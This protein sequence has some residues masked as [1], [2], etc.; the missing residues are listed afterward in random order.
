MTH[1]GDEAPAPTG[2]TY[3]A[4]AEVETLGLLEWR[5]VR[6]QRALLTGPLGGGL[7][8]RRW[9]LNVQV[10]HDYRRLDPDRHLVDLAARLELPESG[11]GMLTAHHVDR[12][13]T[14]LDGGV[15]VTATVGL[16]RPILVVAGPAASPVPEA[17]TINIVAELP[18]RL[19]DAALANALVTVT[20]AKVQALHDAGVHAT[21]TASDAVSVL[22]PPDGE[23]HPFG[24]PRSIGRAPGPGGLP[25]GA[26]WYRGLAARATVRRL[27]L[28]SD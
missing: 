7:G 2:P 26:P 18:A 14:D 5:F 13:I 25:S 27:P 23:P 17:G 6:A 21:G 8:L 9:V 15:R 20:E 1:T 24:G 3:H 16:G 12:F 10:P 28:T 19:S 22:C 4:V 11:V